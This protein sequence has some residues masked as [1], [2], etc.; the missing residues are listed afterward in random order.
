[1]YHDK[2]G[3]EAHME[4]HPKLTLESYSRK[5]E[6]AVEPK[7]KTMGKE[8]AAERNPE[9]TQMK[10]EVVEKS[11]GPDLADKK[12]KVATSPAK[13][14]MSNSSSNPGMIKVKRLL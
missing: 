14:I 2:C 5:Y 1:M 4:K 12:V 10:M 7:A 8:S 3:L 13:S 9:K 6:T 11:P